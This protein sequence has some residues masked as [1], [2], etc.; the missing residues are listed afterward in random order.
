MDSML[1]KAFD[2]LEIADY[3]ENTRRQTLEQADQVF[4]ET[5]KAIKESHQHHRPINKNKSI[6]TMFR[7]LIMKRTENYGGMVAAS[8]IAMT[9]GYAL[10]QTTAIKTIKSPQTQMTEF[11]SLT[12]TASNLSEDNLDKQSSVHQRSAKRQRAVTES[13]QALS[14]EEE[15]VPAMDTY[16]SIIIKQSS[17]PA[18]PSQQIV[19]SDFTYPVP[20]GANQ[21]AEVDN[22]SIKVTANEP[23]STFSI[24]TDTAS[25]SFIRRQLQ[26]GHLPVAEAVRT[27]EMINYFDYN[28]PVNTDI[29]SPFSTTTQ[30]VPSPWNAHNKL[31]HIGIRAVQAQPLIQTKSN[32]VFLIDTSGS[33]QSEDKL[34][35]LISSFKL[36]L[37]TLSDD[38]TVSI[39]TYAGNAGTQLEPTRVKNKAKIINALEH[40]L[41]GGSTAGRAGIQQAYSLAQQHYQ[42]DAVNRVFLA[43]DGDFN[44]G[45]SD[46][47]QLEKFIAKKRDSGVFLSILG[48]GDGNYNDRLM[49][50]L[51]QNGNGQAFYIDNLNEA[52]KVLVEQ[53]SATLIPVAKD[54]KIQ[55]EFNPQVVAQYR[56]IGY[57]SR[58]LKTQDFN[59]DDIDAAEIGAGHTVTAIYEITPVESLQ[60]RIDEP[61]YSDNKADVTTD[62]NFA[63]EFA[64]LKIRYK[65]PDSENSQKMTTA[66]TLDQEKKNLN[67][68][69]SEVQFAVA[70]SAFG[71]RLKQDSNINHY[72]Y[73]DIVALAQASKGDDVYGYRSEFIRLVKLAK[74]IN[75]NN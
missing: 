34:P 10:F 25:Y 20:R 54:V 23:V 49:Q 37:N 55:V 8:L 17:L 24:D 39:V 62:S 41:A 22:N 35:L 56:L 2:S 21:F 30:V 59:D 13:E 29:N 9:I 28:Y 45:M 33:M 73:D 57:E 19:A 50:V 7:S 52:Q 1:N 4:T 31:L 61:R 60:K 16:G 71:Q 36:L 18:E 74:S 12:T 40:L 44:V 48:F 5:S 66:I 27:E 51:A 32:L 42:D 70:V 58:Q 68:A 14:V 26:T 64:F 72:S 63:N 65:Q 6:W 53:A 47:D 43:T 75:Q 38:D 69:N 15:Q 11:E 67:H 46:P 3:S